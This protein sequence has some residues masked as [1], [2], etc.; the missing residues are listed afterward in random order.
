M[1]CAWGH[2]PNSRKSLISFENVGRCLT[3]ILCTEPS[4]CEWK[5]VDGI[6]L[7]Y[8]SASFKYPHISHYISFSFDTLSPVHA[9]LYLIILW[10]PVRRFSLS[11]PV[12][13]FLFQCRHDRSAARVKQDGTKISDPNLERPCNLIDGNSPVDHHLSLLNLFVNCVGSPLS[14]FLQN[15]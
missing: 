12:F 14:L 2:N 9:C 11:V 7:P 3:F 1:L 8:V 15:L 13:L 6:V 10:W 5:S 4:F